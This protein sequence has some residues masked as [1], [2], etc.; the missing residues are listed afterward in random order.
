M[1]HRLGAGV[2]GSADL[3]Y[4]VLLSVAIC[5][6]AV[7]I[8]RRLNVIDHPDK[9][10][11]DHPGP[12][13]L[14]GGIAILVPLAVWCVVRIAMGTGAVEP[15]Y[16]A[17]IFCGGAVALTGFIDDQ[18]PI[19]AIARLPLLAITAGTAMVIDPALVA[20]HVTMASFGVVAIAPALFAVLAAVSL[21]GFV[22]AINMADG[23]NG[24]VTALFFVWA[25]CLARVGGGS[26]AA[27][28]QVVAAGAGVTF[29]FNLRGRLFLGDC[30]TFGIAFVLGL[31]TI[32]AHNAGRLPLETVAAWFFIPVVDCLR[33]VLER[34]FEGR[35]PLKPDTN[36]FHHRLYRSLGERDARW[37]YVGVVSVAS[38]V[39]TFEP[40][41]AAVC[42]ALLSAFYGGFL[43]PEFLGGLLHDRAAK[44][45]AARG[46]KI[47]KVRPA[48]VPPEAKVPVLSAQAAP[49]PAPKPPK[50][51]PREKGPTLQ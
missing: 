20:S 35:S 1:P 42:I 9:R 18:R 6:F 49:P 30:G 34:T 12:T 31:L 32:A 7:P 51:R 41:L 21:V 29:L 2:P 33:L 45:D 24:V 16:A 28:A 19:S 3:T 46:A 38:A 10:R 15:L 47:P 26:I 48:A 14:V 11:K 8:G 23:M 36:H 40:R 25:A 37:T 39:A 22:S 27:A 5:L 4:V 50:P 43:H 44:G 17:I 13:P